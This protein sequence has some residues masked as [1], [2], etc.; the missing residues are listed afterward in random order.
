MNKLIKM[1]PIFFLLL[2]LTGCT[3]HIFICNNDNYNEL[4]VSKD[5]K[6]GTASLYVDIES[7]N[8]NT[9]CNGYIYSTASQRNTK[10]NDVI[11]T[12]TLKC[13]DGRLLRLVELQNVNSSTPIAFSSISRPI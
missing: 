5:Y 9:N 3:K 1:L 13:S 12:G 6:L 7:L 8:T 4:F 2:C 11:F 10:I